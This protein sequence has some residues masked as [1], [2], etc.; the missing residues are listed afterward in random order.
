M[1]NGLLGKKLGMSQVYNEQGEIVPITLIEAGPCDILQIKT[2]Q[3]DGYTA[4]Q[5]GFDDK[6]EKVSTKA[7]IGHCK[8]A[9][10]SPKRF[11]RELSVGS[12][13]Q[14]EIGQRLTVKIFEGVDKLDIS[15]TS[16]GKGFAGVMKRWGFRGGPETHG[17]TRPRGSGSV[18]AGTDPG[19]VL[20]GRKMSGR[21]G[22]DRTTV[23]NLEVV[24]V[25]E[26]A[27]LICVKGAVPGPK[28]G[29]VT[30]KKCK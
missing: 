13:D 27:N 6:K 5:I 9:N 15:G 19:R 23:R 22:G 12:G 7:E 2:A 25:D 10:M 3:V 21:M 18:G 30:L 14:Y 24:K 29:Y 17:S 16:K 8:K 4:I 1:A 20:K 26:S 11:I 28:G